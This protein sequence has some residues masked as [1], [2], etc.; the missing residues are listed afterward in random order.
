MSA[1]AQVTDVRP[2]APELHVAASGTLSAAEIE[3]KEMN[4]WLVWFGTPVLLMA[5]F[6]GATFATESLWGFGAALACLIA[7]IGILIWLCMSSD[8]NG[9]GALDFA[10]SH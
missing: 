7:D 3:A 1:A 2:E 4:R 8:T 5:I 10:P 9:V 6:V